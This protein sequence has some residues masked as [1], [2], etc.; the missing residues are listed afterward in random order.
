MSKIRDF[1]NG[2]SDGLSIF[3]DIMVAIIAFVIMLIPMAILL[4]TLGFMSYGVFRM[5]S[6]TTGL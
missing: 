5:F 2:V 3:G 1:F 6:Y 4:G